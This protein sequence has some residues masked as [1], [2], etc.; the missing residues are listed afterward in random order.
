ML[1]GLEALPLH[2]FETFSS[3]PRNVAAAE[4]YLRRAV[5]A[6][7]DVGRHLLAKRFAVAV[8]EYKAIPTALGER[9]VLDPAQVVLF[10]KICGYR[11]RLVHFYHTES[12]R[13]LHDICVRHAVDLEDVLS[14]LLGWIDAHPD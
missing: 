12:A 11:N 3:D 7:V 9:G 4:S 14:A 2:D 5:E 10:T 6:L 1:A 8:S 13:E